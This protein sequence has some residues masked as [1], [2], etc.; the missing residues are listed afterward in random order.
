M[1]VLIGITVTSDGMRTI[2]GLG[3]R[4]PMYL[5]SQDYCNAI[6]QAG[7]L[8]IVLPF[9]PTLI[10]DI[11]ERLDGVL[12]TGGVDIHP[13]A[14]GE[15][16]HPMLGDV[17]PGRDEFELAFFEK[18]WKHTNLPILG[19]CRGMQLFNVGLGGTLWQ[20]L[21]SQRPGHVHHSQYDHRYKAVHPVRIEPTSQLGGILGKVVAVNSLHHQGVRDIAPGLV[22]IAWSPDGLVEAVEDPTHKFRMAMQWHPENLATVY[23]EVHEVFR[24]FVQAARG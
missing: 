12:F 4:P 24:R 6:S 1:A 20:D 10:D 16:P 18:V 7:A 3:A 15:D 21:P 19:I 13:R 23:P 22:P 5:I 14:Y 2:P 8:P 17:D 9:D 11:L